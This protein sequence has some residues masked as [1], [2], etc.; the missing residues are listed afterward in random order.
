MRVLVVEDDP[1][2]GRAVE[3][4]LRDEGYAV[5]WVR[6]GVEAEIALSSGVYELALLDLAL[7]RRG[8]FE[9]LRTLRV[10]GKEIPV[11]IVTA[12]DAVTDRIAGLDNGA[13]DYLV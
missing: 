12:R 9:I 4:G 8:G 5:D 3:T 10:A 2:L 13:D 7:P 6:D 11:V 1:M